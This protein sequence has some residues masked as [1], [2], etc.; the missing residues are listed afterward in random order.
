MNQSWGNE[1]YIM[2]INGSFYLSAVAD[3][4]GGSVGSLY[5]NRYETLI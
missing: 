2:K 4:N 5:V 3:D 1:K